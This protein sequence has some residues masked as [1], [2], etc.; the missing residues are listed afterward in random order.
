MSALREFGGVTFCKRRAYELLRWSTPEQIMEKESDF[1]GGTTEGNLKIMLENAVSAKEQENQ[2]D[3]RGRLFIS[4][5]CFPPSNW[6]DY[7]AQD[8]SYLDTVKQ[9]ITS[10][11]SRLEFIDNGSSEQIQKLN[12]I[13]DAP[14]RMWVDKLATPGRLDDADHPLDKVMYGPY[15]MQIDTIKELIENVFPGKGEIHSL[16]KITTEEAYQFE[17]TIYLREYDYYGNP[18]PN[19]TPYVQ[20]W[21]LAPGT[22]YYVKQ[23]KVAVQDGVDP[24]EYSV[25][26]FGR[27]PNLPD[28]M[29]SNNLLGRIWIEVELGSMRGECLKLYEF[30]IHFHPKAMFSLHWESFECLWPIYDWSMFLL[31]YDCQHLSLAVDFM[32]QPGT[33]L[34]YQR[35][36]KSLDI[37]GAK[38]N[39]EALDRDLILRKM[40]VYYDCPMDVEITYTI[41]DKR[42]RPEVHATEKIT[43]RTPQFFKLER[44]IRV[45]FI[46]IFAYEVAKTYARES[47]K[48]YEYW[49]RSWVELAEELEYHELAATLK[50]CKPYRDSSRLSIDTWFLEI[51]QPLLQ[52]EKLQAVRPDQVI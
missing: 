46:A 49:Y 52:K 4:H 26:K 1:W 32:L 12:P 21:E 8:S 45:T 27:A 6:S 51:C 29:A 23:C 11:F 44:Y 17:N 48:S 2:D 38:R 28:W 24:S 16:I 20:K 5:T 40:A 47:Y 34:M 9:Q 36:I 14:K 37:A 50:K 41:P 42:K 7:I 33:N 43:T 22:S 35:M 30:L 39:V 10:S 25:Y 31:K 18:K 15:L 19:P 13:K 3:D